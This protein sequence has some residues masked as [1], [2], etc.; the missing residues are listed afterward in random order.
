MKNL[1][2]ATLM[3]ALLLPAPEAKAWWGRYGSAYEA[4]EACNAWAKDNYKRHQELRPVNARSTAMEW[5]WIVTEAYA[6]EW[7]KET[8]QV[9]AVSRLTDK[10]SKRFRY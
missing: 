4:K 10:V 1:L 3:A 7:D 8:N 6:C 9:L 5:K 2:Y